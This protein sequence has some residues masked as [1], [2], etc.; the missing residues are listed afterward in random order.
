MGFDLA[1]YIKQ[2]K[3]SFNCTVNPATNQTDWM[4]TKPDGTL[5]TEMPQCLY[6]CDHE[7]IENLKLYNRTWVTGKF[8]AGTKASYSCAGKKCQISDSTRSS[9]PLKHYVSKFDHIF[10]T[11]QL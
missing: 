2:S 5:S 7:P 9:A 3:L 1:L 10:G 4:Y 6:I 11:S 8:S